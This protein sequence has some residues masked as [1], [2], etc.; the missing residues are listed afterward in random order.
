MKVTYGRMILLC[1]IF[2]LAPCSAYS[3]STSLVEI[4]I[5]FDHAN[6]PMVEMEIAKH[7]IKFY[8][9]TGARGLHLP[10]AIAETINGVKLTGRTVK[11]V[12]LAGK[13]R[14]DA[15]FIIPELQ[16]DGMIFLRIPNRNLERTLSIGSKRIEKRNDR[17]V[18]GLSIVACRLHLR[19]NK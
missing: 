5:S 3:S 13:V 9:D 15:E 2:V 8:L 4:P 11:S 14:E 6:L 10:K 7:H 1:I 18:N 12:D 19:N 17:I 16:M